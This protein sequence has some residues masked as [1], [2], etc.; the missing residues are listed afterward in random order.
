MLGQLV[1]ILTDTHHIRDVIES[2][3]TQKSS[4]LTIKS[5]S[6]VSK[7]QLKELEI[8]VAAPQFSWN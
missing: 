3:K 6:Q 4:D 7:D 8:K 2:P 1:M 5:P